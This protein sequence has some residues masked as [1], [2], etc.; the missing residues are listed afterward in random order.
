MTRVPLALCFL[1]SFPFIIFHCLASL[2]LVI[3]LV[4]L[5][6][7]LHYFD[8]RVAAT[9]PDLRRQETEKIVCRHSLDRLNA[10][11]IKQKRLESNWGQTN[12][13]FPQ[14]FITAARFTLANRPKMPKNSE[15]KLTYLRYNTPPRHPLFYHC[16]RQILAPTLRQ[17]IKRLPQQLLQYLPLLFLPVTPAQGILYDL[18]NPQIPTQREIA[19]KLLWDLGF[20]LLVSLRIHYRCGDVGVDGWVAFEETFGRSMVEARKWRGSLTGT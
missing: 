1:C 6:P 19:D 16:L 5:F 9:E 18:E 15:Q 20:C 11:M 17:P 13:H 10:S 3:S 14:R 8:E 12:H 4:R 2:S 7:L